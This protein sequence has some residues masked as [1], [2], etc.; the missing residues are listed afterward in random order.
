MQQSHIREAGLRAE[1]EARGKP[2]NLGTDQAQQAQAKAADPNSSFPEPVMDS[3]EQAE[4]IKSNQGPAANMQ[5]VKLDNK[6]PLHVPVAGNR[7][8]RDVPGDVV[9]GVNLSVGHFNTKIG[10][11]EG[12]RHGTGVDFSNSTL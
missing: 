1:A 10:D 6:T 12:G 3:P 4:A 11:T 9:A 8:Q 2:V 5:G 7:G